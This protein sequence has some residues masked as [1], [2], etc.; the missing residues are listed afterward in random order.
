MKTVNGQRRTVTTRWL[1]ILGC[2]LAA[3]AVGVA[4]AHTFTVERYLD[5]ERVASPRVSP[6]GNRIVFARSYVDQAKDAWVSMLWIMDADGGRLRQLVKGTSQQWSPDGGRIAYLAE[7]DGKTQLWVRYMDAEGAL[8]QVTRGER[9]PES[10]KW[11]PDGKWLAF[12]MVVPE[13]VAWPIPMPSAPKGVTWTPAPMIVDRLHYRADRTGFLADG[14][15]HVFLVQTEGGTP[16]DIT[17][18]QFNAGARGES[19]PGAVGMDWMLDGKTIIVDGNDDPDADRQYRVSNLY[20]VDVATGRRRKMI[21]QPGFWG[22]PVLS[23]DG[24]SLAYTGFPA[25]TNSYRAR[26]L[27]VARID[28][29]GGRIVTPGLDRDP[30]SV[31]WADNESLWFTV[32]DHGAVNT[33]SASTTAKVLGARPGSNGAHV[34]SLGSISPK[35]NFGVVVRS[36]PQQPEEIYRFSFKKPFEFTQ[37]T[38]VNDDLLT[39]LKL[40]DVEE[41]EF[42]AAD[43]TAL[44][45]WVVKP[46]DFDQAKKYPLIL[47]IHGG[48]HAMYNVAFNPSFQ[49]FAAYGNLVLYLNPRGST[50]YGTAFGNAIMKAYPGVDYDDLMLGVNEVIGRGWVDTTR[51]YVGGCSGG[52]VLSS[53]II[54]HTTRFAAAAVRCPVIN[55]LSFLGE[56]DIPL[57]AQQWFDKPF[58][59][60]PTAWLKF[61]PLMYV[62]NVTTPT[63]LM[64]GD[65]DMRTPLP[66]TEEYYAALKLRGVPATLLR[67]SGEYHGTATKPS[68][69]MRTQLYMMSWYGRYP[70]GR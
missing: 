12:S 32:E 13:A 20:A 34:I 35:G 51:M 11:S 46:P 33:W 28:G 14:S 67:F 45:G 60:D 36:A 31:T 3:P 56:T 58:W 42:K 55:W 43:G 69:W 38:H 66:Q 62:G 37:L 29:M 30:T 27:Y 16:R 10:F 48:P 24:K 61:S 53:W 63:L 2:L 68:N 47:E 9:A 21:T 57:F 70:G 4:Q 49:D 52:G 15:T 1:L 44:H 25:T 50:G 54:G 8:V 40:G 39:N 59:E 17:P 22:N 65:L 41:V 23:P 6:D 7:N 19:G 18:G 5:L 26:D 64:T